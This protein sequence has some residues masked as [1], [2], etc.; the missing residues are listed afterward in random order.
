VLLLR[1]ISHNVLGVKPAPT[2]PPP[3]P[4]AF[5]GDDRFVCLEGPLKD[6][7]GEVLRDSAG[8]VRWIRAGG[9]VYRRLES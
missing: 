3:A 4:I 6:V 9:R 2:D 1:S 8:S 7:R 5:I